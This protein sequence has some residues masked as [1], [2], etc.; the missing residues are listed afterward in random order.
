V[1][2]RGGERGGIEAHVREDVSD[3]EKMREIRFAGAAELVV[4]ALGGYFVGAA[5]H[6]GIF[7]RAVLAKL[8]EELFEAR[9][10]LANGAVAVEA[11]RE[12]ARRRHVLVYARKGA[13][14]ENDLR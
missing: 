6:P 3:F 12:I 2:N 14:R 5:N 1:E 10:Q 13:S 11:K 7:G 9:V 8:F 4:V